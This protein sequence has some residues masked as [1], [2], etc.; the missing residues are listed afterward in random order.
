MA[1]APHW[2]LVLGGGWIGGVT[3]PGETW[4]C[5][6]NCDDDIVGALDPVAWLAAHAASDIA[7]WFTNPANWM[8]SAAVLQYVKLNRIG[9]DG[10]YTDPTHPHTFGLSPTSGG[11]GASYPPFLSVAYTWTTA[12]F[13]GP[14]SKGRVYLP[15]AVQTVSPSSEFLS[16]LDSANGVTSAKNLLT[17]VHSGLA[18]ARLVPVVASNVDAS[19]TPITGV[20]VGSVIDVQRRR[21]NKGAEV[22]VASSWP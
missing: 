22:Y 16:D 13:R 10:R 5:S 20:R 17:A 2:R 12:R 9:A 3:A 7:G 15:T 6:V 8:S 21:K 18:G 19:L 11:R 4:E 14:G 1:Y